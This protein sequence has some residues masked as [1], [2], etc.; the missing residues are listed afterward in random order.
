M[1]DRIYYALSFIKVVLNLRIRKQIREYRKL[2]K[3]TQQQLADLAE[4]DV[5]HLSAIENGHINPS[6]GTLIQ[7]INT[8]GVSANPFFA[9]CSGDDK[10]NRKPVYVLDKRIAAA[11]KRC[12]TA[13]RSFVYCLIETMVEGLQEQDDDDFVEL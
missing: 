1:N 13:K 9:A 12:P 3:M 4:I 2:R 7:I 8:L 6:M 5:S 10:N 11:L